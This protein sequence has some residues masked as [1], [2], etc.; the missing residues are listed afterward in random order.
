MQVFD[1]LTTENRRVFAAIEVLDPLLVILAHVGSEVAL[2]C[3]V[4]LVHVRVR[5]QALFKVHARQQWILCH[6][7][8]EDVEVQRQF[9][10]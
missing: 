6:H 2:V 10:H 8:V 1:A 4:V 9:V 5:L 3:L 7:F